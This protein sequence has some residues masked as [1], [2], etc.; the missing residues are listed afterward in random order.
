MLAIRP[1]LSLLRTPEEIAAARDWPK[2]KAARCAFDSPWRDRTDWPDAPY[3]IRLRA[4]RD[5]ETV[6]TTWSKAP[7][8]WPTP[9]WTT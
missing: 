3:V 4:P 1:R 6:S 8:A 2:P 7:S 9:N 5:G